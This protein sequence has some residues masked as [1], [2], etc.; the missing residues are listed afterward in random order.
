MQGIVFYKGP[1]QINGGPIV[2][3]AT[4]LK[5]PSP[6][7][8][9]GPLVQTYFLVDGVHPMEAVHTGADEAVCGSCRH[10]GIIVTHPD[11]GRQKNIERSCYVTLMHGPAVV[12]QSYQDGLYPEVTPTI[13][14]RILSGRQIRV[15]AFGD[16][17][18]VPFNVLQT[19]LSRARDISG[20]THHWEEFPELAAFCMASVDTEEERSRAKSLGFRTFRV[21]SKGAPVLAGEGQ[22]PASA[23]MGKAAQC[24]T[25]LLCGGQTTKARADVTIIVHGAR[26]KH[27]RPELETA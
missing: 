23:E 21:R 15:G 10:R 1:S 20:Y 5:Y 26:A 3:I 25:C 19:V 18:S 22:C 9:T 27:F 12:Y 24:C 13:A 16:P 4:G 14:R 11:T 2:S 6:N 8:K 7:T 17:A